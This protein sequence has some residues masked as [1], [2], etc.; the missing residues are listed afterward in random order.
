MSRDRRRRLH[1]EGNPSALVESRGVACI[2]SD[3]D[4]VEP[5]D[6]FL[7][8]SERHPLHRPLTESWNNHFMPLVINKFSFDMGKSVYNAIPCVISK[9]EEGSA[10]YLACSAVGRAYIANTTW[11]PNVKSDRAKAYGTALAAV[12][13]AL[14]DPEQRKSDNT[15]LGVWLLS[16]YEVR[17]YTP[18]SSS[19]LT[20]TSSSCF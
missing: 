1:R 12:N 16:L 11:S 20:H 18:G 9:A 8:S 15:L 14:R 17:Y 5:T 10:L 2:T 3:A 19:L 6:Q 7:L 4:L 13:S